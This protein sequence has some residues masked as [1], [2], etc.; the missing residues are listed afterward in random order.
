MTGAPAGV[1]APSL[2]SLRVLIID[3]DPFMR[4]FEEQL[5]RTFAM[6]EVWTAG[7]GTCARELVEDLAIC[8]DAIVCDLDMPEMDGI[9]FVHYLSDQRFTGGVII[10][11]GAGERIVA[12]VGALAR[13]LDLH[14][15]ASLNKPVDPET[16]RE[17]L[18]MIRSRT[19][20]ATHEG[21]PQSR[22]ATL[23]ADAVRDGIA[24]GFAEICVQPQVSL[25]DRRVTGVEALLRWTDPE[26]GVLSPMAVIPVAED[27][28]LIDDLTLAVYRRAIECLSACRRDGLDMRISVNLSTLNLHCLD[29][30]ERLSRIAAGAGVP[31]GHVVLE[32]TESRLINDISASLEVLGRLRLHGFG[33][34]VDDFGTGYSSLELLRQLPFNE[35]KVDQ[36]FVRGARTDSAARTIIESAV[37]LGRNLGMRV[38]VEGVE[39]AADWSLVE[40]FR[41]DA[42]QGYYVARPMPPGEFHDWVRNLARPQA[43]SV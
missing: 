33:L 1:R 20:L 3:D 28:G 8:P 11:S 4:A 13:S 12:S 29:L 27:A 2:G 7:D 39:T 30:P 32:I 22:F 5:V 35:L 19:A 42:V 41:C 23:D 36:T 21:R 9:E 6:G 14:L 37:A 40:Q 31:N 10:A 15:V 25:A 16:L 17:A 18:V 43:R 38:V 26:R 24:R 34:A